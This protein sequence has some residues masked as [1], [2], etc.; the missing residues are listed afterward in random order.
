MSSESI[1]LIDEMVIPDTGASRFASQLD[2]TMM[3]TFNSCERTNSQWRKLLAEVGLE[4]KEAYSYD[5]EMEYT[6]LEVVSKKN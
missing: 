5:S 4:I 1:L 6:I 2:I 3:A